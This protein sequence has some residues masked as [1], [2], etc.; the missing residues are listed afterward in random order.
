MALRVI[1]KMKKK[2]LKFHL[3]QFLVQTL[4]NILLNMINLKIMVSKLC[5]RI[6]NLFRVCS[7]LKHCPCLFPTPPFPSFLN[8]LKNGLTFNPRFSSLASI[9]VWLSSPPS[10]INWQCLPSFWPDSTTT[11]TSY[12]WRQYKHASS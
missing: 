8:V 10:P 11:T 6:K 12:A 4:P 5:V 7:P 9:Y 2:N 1:I 3:D